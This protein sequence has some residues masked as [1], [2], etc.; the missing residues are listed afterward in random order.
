MR[1]FLGFLVARPNSANEP[2]TNQF[3]LRS[4]AATR[5]L[6]VSGE[7]ERLWASSGLELAIS[8]FRRCRLGHA[9]LRMAA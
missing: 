1:F 9:A 8:F 4:A 6:Q 2:S 7:Y 5:E 3:R